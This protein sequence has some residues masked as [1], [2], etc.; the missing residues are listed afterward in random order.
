METGEDKT[1]KVLPNAIEEEE[2]FCKLDT[3]VRECL[4]KLQ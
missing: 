3:E 1:K 4:E 2:D